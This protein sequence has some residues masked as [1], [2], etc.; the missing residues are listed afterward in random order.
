MV[1]E[2]EER[3]TKVLNLLKR[4]RLLSSPSLDKIVETSTDD[5]GTLEQSLR[6]RVRSGVWMT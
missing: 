6:P 2:D 4:S 5:V 1:E 3:S